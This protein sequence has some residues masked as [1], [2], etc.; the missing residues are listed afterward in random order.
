[1]RHQRAAAGVEREPRRL[2][3]SAVRRSGMADDQVIRRVLM[4]RIA[5]LH[6][7]KTAGSALRTILQRNFALGELYP[8]YTEQA[9]AAFRRMSPETRDRIK[10][11]YGHFCLD[12]ADWLPDDMVYITMLRDPVERVASL[13]YFNRFV[14]KTGPEYQLPLRV[15]LEQR[16]HPPIDNWMVR[17]LS[18]LTDRIPSGE[19][20]TDMLE[21]AK[22]AAD[23]F[24][25]IGISERFHESHALLCRLF[26]FPVRYCPPTNVNLNRPAM[27]TISPADI[28]LIEQYNR[29]DREL[30]L[31]C[32][33]R[34]DRELAETDVSLQLRELLRRRDG[35]R[36]RT[37][38]I[39]NQNAREQWRRLAKKLLGKRQYG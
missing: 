10:V 28:A 16:G 3:A 24:F 27:E 36:L 1:M 12:V 23:R 6:I 21:A 34:L 37:F 22:Q 19:C 33:R 14:R 8:M 38:D 20:T 5:F 30:Y 25:F 7:E 29:L 11:V 2:S 39:F 31:H 15:Y 18:G 35:I 9:R 4:R 32:V 13:Y 17:C 26:G